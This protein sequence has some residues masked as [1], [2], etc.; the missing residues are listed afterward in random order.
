MKT[1]SK[2]IIGSASAFFFAL[3]MM[4]SFS[5]Q[6]VQAQYGNANYQ[7]F[8]NDLAP[9]GTWMNDPQYGYVWAPN[10]GGGFRPYYTNGYWAMTEYGNMWVS[11]YPWGW[12]PFHYGRWA[13][14]DYYGWIWI[15]GDEWGPAWVT[16]R[17]GGGYYGWA[18]MGPG[19]TIGMSFGS[20]YYY[21][22]PYWT[23][24]PCNYI[25]S[26]SFHRYYSPR[27][28][29]NVIRNTT[30]INNTYVDNRSRHTYVTGPR[31]SD[32]ERVTGRSVA[33][34]RV[35]PGRNSG[36]STVSGRTINT[37]R[38]DV[39]K[40]NSGRGTTKAAPRT[41]KNMERPLNA[42]PHKTNSRQQDVQNRNARSVN[43]SNNNVQPRNEQ[44][45]GQP[46]A[47]PRKNVSPNRSRVPKRPESNVPERQIRTPQ[48]SN[49]NQEQSRPARPAQQQER[50]AAPPQRRETSP[51]TIN[52]R[53][54][55]RKTRSVNP[56]TN[57]KAERS[58]AETSRRGHR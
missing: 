14:S 35:N 26:R 31:R 3:F 29:G 22:D 24:I 1:L 53:P 16:W 4:L 32:V 45:R 52:Q 55:E 28:T 54:V 13:Y 34:Y 2:E 56:G 39:R 15:P 51:R 58:S 9:Y 7:T 50:S 33:T 44:R 49:R 23:F 57:R 12:A 10:A 41:V 11:N 42:A 48:N 47:T 30:I 25:Y 36:R 46:Q 21:P 38:P 5:S 40:V 37:Y 6:K 20:G 17:Q 19:M 43:P 27:R 8:Y 18:P